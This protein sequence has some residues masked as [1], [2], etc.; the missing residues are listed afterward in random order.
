M[1]KFIE[2]LQRRI[3]IAKSEERRTNERKKRWRMQ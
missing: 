2:T 3:I 1:Q